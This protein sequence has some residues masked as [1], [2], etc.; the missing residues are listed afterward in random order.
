MFV[1]GP[2]HRPPQ[3]LEPDEALARA[4]RSA[5]RRTTAPVRG[6]RTRP[7]RAGRPP[8]RPTGRRTSHARAPRRRGCPLLRRCARRF[9]P[10]GSSTTPRRSRDR[11]S[12]DSTRSNWRARVSVRTRIRR[13]TPFSERSF[14]ST[15][16]AHRSCLARSG[17]AAHGCARRLLFELGGPSFHLGVGAMR[18]RSSGAFTRSET[19]DEATSRRYRLLRALPDRGSGIL[20]STSGGSS[21]SRTVS[22]KTRRSCASTVGL[23]SRLE[24]TTAR[25]PRRAPGTW[26]TSPGLR[27]ATA[28]RT[29]SLR[30]LSRPTRSSSRRC[31]RL[32]Q[33]APVLVEVAE[34]ARHVRPVALD[35]LPVA[36]SHALECHDPA[37]REEL[38]ER[39]VEE[40]VRLLGR[41][42]AHQVDGHVVRGAERR[43][44]V[45]RAGRSQRRDAFE[46]HLLLVD[47][48]PRARARR[49]RA[50]PRDR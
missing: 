31:R 14:S 18:R 32:P 5:S 50:V 11:S 16:V 3:A 15:R 4:L 19:S 33:E 36:L 29:A 22:R 34:V 40:V 17:Q 12:T 39:R 25:P 44:Q 46:R 2:A 48:P 28:A 20:V 45:V 23:P 6:L 9:G 24:T 38:R 42:V 30:A 49:C 7:R 26:M 47:A 41:V 8:R 10:S 13:S 21:K 27:D 1:L 37:V 35:R 43:G